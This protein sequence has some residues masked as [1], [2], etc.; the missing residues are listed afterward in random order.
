MYP[1]LDN[2]YVNLVSHEDASGISSP[3]CNPSSS[4]F[5]IFHSGKDI[6]ESITTHDYTWDDM[7]HRVYFLLQ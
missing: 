5:P 3:S 1:N 7:H 2:A 6:M 4:S